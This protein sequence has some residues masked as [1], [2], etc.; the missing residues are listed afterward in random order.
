[1]T[2][3]TAGKVPVLECFRASWTFLFQNWQLFV[4]AAAVVGAVTGLSLLIAGG[5]AAAPGPA[6]LSMLPPLVASVMFTAAVLRK[7]VRDEFSGPAGLGFGVDE[8]RLL[9]VLG[10]IVLLIFPA[11]FLALMVFSVYIVGRLGMTEQ[12]LEAL[13]ADPEALAKA[14]TEALGPSGILAMYGLFFAGFAVLVYVLAKLFMVN[15]ATI[16]EKKI[17]FFQTW[18]W[19][20]GNTYRIILAMLLTALP[21]VGVNLLLQILV[22]SMSASLIAAVVVNAVAGAIAALLNIPQ[23]ALGAHLYKGLRPPGFVAK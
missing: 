22:A 14:M 4:P 21:A 15:A 8:M 7:A 2:D 10:S 12:Q 3:A 6:L 19:S 9:G 13:S 16:G 20:K 1:M 17:V 11:V 5:G 23:I 18:A